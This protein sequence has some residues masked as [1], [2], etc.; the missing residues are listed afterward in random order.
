M[1]NQCI[2]EQVILDE[3]R[4]YISKISGALASGSEIGSLFLGRN[5]SQGPRLAVLEMHA[6]AIIRC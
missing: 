1:L 4:K 6:W 5:G 3:D 2:E